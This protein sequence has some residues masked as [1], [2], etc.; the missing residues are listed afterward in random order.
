MSSRTKEEEAAGHQKDLHLHRLL[1][2]L[3]FTLCYHKVGHLLSSLFIYFHHR[4]LWQ[5]V[6]FLHDDDDDVCVRV[7]T[8]AFTIMVPEENQTFP[9]SGVSDDTI[10]GLY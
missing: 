9:V 4:L 3:L 5:L 10:M 6:N 7:S 2:P 1:H 8:D